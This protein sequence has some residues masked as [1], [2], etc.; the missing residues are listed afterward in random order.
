MALMIA[1][2][3]A[4]T[5]GFGGAEEGASTFAEY[6]AG[7][8][9]PMLAQRYEGVFAVGA[10]LSSQALSD[11]KAV[12]LIIGHFNALAGESQM[13][14]ETLLDRSASK[15]AKDPAHAKVSFSKA[16]SLLKFAQ[17][18]GL[19]LR[20]GALVGENAPRWFFAEGWSSLDSAPLVDRD[21]M[22]R[23]LENFIRDVMEYVNGKYPGVVSAWDVAENAVAPTQG[24]RT[25]DNLWYETIGED[26]IELAFTFARQYAREGQ[27]L[28]YGDDQCDDPE[29]LG[30]LTTLLSG[31]KEKGL[32]DGVSVQSA[33]T[34]DAPDLQSYEAALS[35][36]AALGL[37][38][39]VTDL[40]FDAPNDTNLASMRQAARCR[41][42]FSL[43]ERLKTQAG[44]PIESV[45]FWGVRDDLAPADGEEKAGFSLLFDKDSRCKAAFFGAL[46]DSAIPLSAENEQLLKAMEAL[47]IENNTNEEEELPVNV[48]KALDRHNPVM[49][50]RFG[51]DPWA[52][53]YQDRVYLYM[54][55]DEPMKDAEGNIRT[56]DYSNITT[57]RVLSSA[58][59]VNW[60]DHGSVNAAGRSGAAKWASNSWAPAAAWKNI[61][62]QDKFFLYFAN[63]GGGIGVLT[64]DSPTGPF[65][66]P[67]GKALVSRNTPTCQSVTWLFDPA[68]L[69]DDDGSAYLY[70]GGGIP[71]GKAS[72]PGTAR[73]VKL[74]E[75]MISL[76]GDPVAIDPPWLFEDS[77]INKFGD[78]Y[79]Y[80]YCSNFNVPASGSK[81]GFYSGEI[82]YMT[83][84][85]PMGP[86]TYAGRVLKNPSAY[87]GVGGNNHHC[88]FEFKGQTYITYH[89]ATVDRDMKWN[90]GYRSTFVDVLEMGENGLPALSKGTYQGVSQLAAFDPYQAVNGATA[91]SM[92]GMETE[93][94]HRENRGAGSGDMLARSLSS[95]AWLAVAQAD[96]GEGA[97]AVKLTYTADEGAEIEILLDSPD[98]APAA[99]IAL[100]P[101]EE[102][103]AEVFDLGEV[104]T[105]VHDLYFRFTKKNTALLEWQFFSP[106]SGQ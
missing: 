31:F 49:V 20:A 42:V 36:F 15:K 92:A 62:G 77:G 10:A 21:T 105:G 78:T 59:L 98:G 90:A 43:L 54:T 1:L 45:T 22:I 5:C 11:D 100:T 19:P 89:A 86:F 68:V 83:S 39:H 87:F 57:L 73:V 55:G 25:Q 8:Q 67:L 7:G 75:D 82:V 44:Y 18:A 84:S 52:M 63:S 56:N 29:K 61:D 30:H 9:A 99:A 97:A 79:V 102:P 80:S 104:L 26:Y 13:S 71:E 95:G 2:A 28:L 85:S 40:R 96:F 4:L 35:A 51:A 12:S 74:G 106:L 37:S 58:D 70:F 60:Q 23:R 64:S 24:I 3:L 50:Q 46:Q 76:D 72:A 66:D 53:V 34:L 91:A 33:F 47:G 93:L 65:T 14:P 94:I 17:E 69:V 88:M 48:Y 41:A 6:L 101:A 27:Q 81:Q 32:I 38:L 16:A 103:R